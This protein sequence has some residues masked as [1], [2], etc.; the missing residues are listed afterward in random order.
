MKGKIVAL[1]VAMVM[2]LSGCNVANKGD[3]TSVVNGDS[4][5]SEVIETEDN[6]TA[7]QSIVESTSNEEATVEDVATKSSSNELP[8]ADK[9]IT[10]KNVDWEM[11]D[12]I[13]TVENVGDITESIVVDDAGIKATFLRMY[14]DGGQ[15]VIEMK[16]DNSS[17]RDI[18]AIMVHSSINDYMVESL[19][20]IEVGAGESATGEFVLSGYDIDVYDIDTV[21][22]VEFK[23]D[24]F[25]TNDYT[26]VLFTNPIVL[27]TSNYD[28]YEF[29]FND[30]GT[31]IYNDNGFRVVAKKATDGSEYLDS[32][33]VVYL[34]NDTDTDMAIL[35][36]DC[37]INGIE[38]S[39]W[40]V[41]ELAAGKSIIDEIRSICLD[42]SVDKSELDHIERMRLSITV[43]DAST[44]TELFNTGT[45]EMVFE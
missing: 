19:G 45:I 31:E 39:G 15:L 32:T 12:G 26:D 21:A 29:N 7:E 10:V 23:L 3:S 22:S 33:L 43:C 44:Y 9:L 41:S 36:D 34:E 6:Q 35:I 30:E 40:S 13:G 27:K 4:I 24:V 38:V 11:L 42:E 1:V 18:S 5:E 37:Y 25:D 14:S 16:I 8:E 28:G 2:C 17:T 20:S